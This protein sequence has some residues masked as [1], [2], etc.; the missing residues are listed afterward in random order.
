M[1]AISTVLVILLLVVG[2]SGTS[3]ND[4][5]GAAPTEP[6]LT[7]DEPAPEPTDPESS[8]PEE[9][10]P[11]F[12]LATAPVGG[13]PDEAGVEQCAAVSLTGVELKEGTTVDL[14]PVHLEPEGIF[15]LDDSICKDRRP[16]K[17]VQWKAGSLDSCYVGARQIANGSSEVK[18]VVPAQVTCATEEDCSDLKA[19]AGKGSFVFFIPGELTPAPSETPETPTGG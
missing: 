6:V 19:T 5:P 15:Q 17:D 3:S 16:C 7:S 12:G 11:G 13:A 18:V 10:K 14:G 2:C 4:P 8:Q 9:K 1:R